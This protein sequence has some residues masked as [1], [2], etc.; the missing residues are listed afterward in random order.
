MGKLVIIKKGDKTNRKL[1]NHLTSCAVLFLLKLTS[2]KN[3]LRTDE[4]G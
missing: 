1:E 4:L 3:V 2:G